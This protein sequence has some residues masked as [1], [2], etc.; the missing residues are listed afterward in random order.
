[1]HHF[2]SAKGHW[3]Q[4]ESQILHQ[5]VDTRSLKAAQVQLWYWNQT[6]IFLMYLVSVPIIL[7]H[8]WS[9]N[10]LFYFYNHTSIP[11]PPGGCPTS[12]HSTSFGNAWPKTQQ[13]GWK[14]VPYLTFS[15]YILYHNVLSICQNP[16]DMF[17]HYTIFHLLF[18]F[19]LGSDN[20]GLLVIQYVTT[21]ENS[22]CNIG[23]T[24]SAP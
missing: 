8:F 19:V 20:S 15:F 13:S 2:S 7:S 11:G 9:L 16:L 12:S 5:V 21:K 22:T 17:C 4:H 6:S 3:V 23:S 18:S 10:T 1:M 24:Y 14:H